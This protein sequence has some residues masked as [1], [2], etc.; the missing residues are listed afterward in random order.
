MA[1]RA[2]TQLVDDID[3]TVLS[4]GDGQTATF[5]VGNKQYEIDLSDENAARFHDVLKPYVDAGRRVGSKRGRQPN[6]DVEGRTVTSVVDPRAVRAW[7]ASNGIEVSARGRVPA[8]L[9]EQF[10]AAGN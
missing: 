7:A 8:R 1:R 2:I 5:A 3:G 6:S 9:L 4:E 10:K